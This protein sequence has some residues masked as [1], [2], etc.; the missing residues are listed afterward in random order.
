[1]INPK[2]KLREN[3]YVLCKFLHVDFEGDGS[4]KE[5][6]ELYYVK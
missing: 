5:V 3:Y 6:R 4:L 2:M 1:V